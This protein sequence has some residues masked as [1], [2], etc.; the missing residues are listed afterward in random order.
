MKEA[1]PTGGPRETRR[2]EARKDLAL[3]LLKALASMAAAWACATPAA[4]ATLQVGPTRTV[5]Y[6]EFNHGDGQGDGQSHNM[7]IG[8]CN[9]FTLRYCWSHNAVVGRQVKTRAQVNYVLYNL[10]SD[11]GGSGSIEADIPQ[12]G[13]SCVIGN[14]NTVDV[15]DL[16][17][18]VDN[19][20]RILE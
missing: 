9:S 12:V 10:V 20:G 7:Y 13:T 15:V 3:K 6:S 11:D 18:M 17:N 1:E 19:F 2:M 16:L 5:E 14:D 8:Y 4:A